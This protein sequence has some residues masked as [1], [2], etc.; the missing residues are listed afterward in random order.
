MQFT[1]L[2]IATL[3]GGTIEGN[4]EVKVSNIARIE[5]ATNTSLSFV[6]NPKYE[7]YIYTTEAAILILNESTVL[8]GMASPTLIRVK[9]AYSSFALL[10]DKYNEHMTPNSR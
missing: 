5:E 2:Q 10:L 9:D 8:S 7:D 6:A 1:A 4:P 3:V